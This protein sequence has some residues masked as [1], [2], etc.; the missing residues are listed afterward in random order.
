MR[1]PGD[2]EQ[3]FREA[4][5]S[6]GD[7]VAKVRVRCAGHD[8]I[9][10]VEEWE[11][12][13]LD[14]EY[15]AGHQLR[16][17]ALDGAGNYLIGRSC[18]LRAPALQQESE[19]LV[20]K[21]THTKEIHSQRKRAVVPELSCATCPIHKSNAELARTLVSL[22]QSNLKHSQGISVEMTRAHTDLINTALGTIHESGVMKAKVAEAEGTVKLLEAM[23]PD[24][25]KHATTQRAMDIA[26]RFVV[27]LARSGGDDETDTSKGASPGSSAP[28][29]PPMPGVTS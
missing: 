8:E 5:A 7:H 17:E 18:K 11:S 4:M 19:S 22:L 12:R 21:E 20:A 15:S 10:P 23:D 28:P 13:V 16:L 27:E 1:I 9:A 6:K 26:E 24:A 2:L 14:A 3:R 29:P 25:M